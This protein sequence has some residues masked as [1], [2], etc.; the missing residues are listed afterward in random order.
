MSLRY[1]RSKEL[2]NFV[3]SSDS[4]HDNKRNRTRSSFHGDPMYV[5]GLDS[6]VSLKQRIVSKN[7]SLGDQAEGTR[8]V[9]SHET[10][11]VDT[12]NAHDCLNPLISTDH[13]DSNSGPSNLYSNNTSLDLK[14]RAS[15]SHLRW[16]PNNSTDPKTGPVAHHLREWKKRL[17]ASPLPLLDSCADN[18]KY[19]RRSY[20]RRLENRLQKEMEHN[21]L[22]RPE[23]ISDILENGIVEYTPLN[24]GSHVSATNDICSLK[25]YEI[26]NVSYYQKPSHN[27]RLKLGSSSSFTNV[28]RSGGI[29][30]TGQ[31]D[32]I[33]GEQSKI[34]NHGKQDSGIENCRRSWK[35]FLN[36]KRVYLDRSRLNKQNDGRI[37]LFHRDLI[38]LLKKEFNIISSSTLDQSVS[39]IITHGN[40]RLD[41]YTE[42]QEQFLQ[43]RQDFK[44]LVWSLED[45]L[46]LIQLF[47]LE[48]NTLAVDYVP[49]NG[50]KRPHRTTSGKSGSEVACKTLQE[51]SL[52]DLEIDS[53]INSS[54]IDSNYQNIANI[55][56]KK[57]AVKLGLDVTRPYH[58][59]NLASPCSMAVGA[60]RHISDSFSSE[61]KISH[62]KL[63]T[64]TKRILRDTKDAQYRSDK[65]IERISHDIKGLD[66]EIKVLTSSLTNLEN[67]IKSHE[68]SIR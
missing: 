49:T 55:K 31:A 64:I 67:Q 61:S 40:N 53:I 46:H 59:Y 52:R 6:V 66:M 12:A 35:S 37:E 36:K 5:T 26:S 51:I 44:C 33:S 28:K 21:N 56:Q 60:K 20:D 13:Y 48:S 10:L 54:D 1:N 63:F 22:L 2:H 62:N 57:G 17:A 27:D 18:P 32:R 39:V 11:S 3:K 24:K 34:K 42:P 68:N 50:T 29:W 7:L 25:N 30:C 8:T 14:D 4:K 65:F 16:T 23:I 45:I 43:L 58:G 15:R 47:G 38:S 9:P 41:L 19:E